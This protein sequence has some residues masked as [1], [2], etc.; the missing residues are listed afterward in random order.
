MKF[1]Y[2]VKLVTLDN[3]AELIS[4]QRIALTEE[5]RDTA[6]NNWFTGR[7]DRRIDIECI[8]AVD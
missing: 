3:G 2:L 4:D 8:K 6:V 7:A 5:E 1:Y